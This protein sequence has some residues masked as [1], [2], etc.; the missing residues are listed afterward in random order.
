VTSAEFLNVIEE[1]LE[2]DEGILDG[3]ELI[4]DLEGWDSL[5]VVSFI[6]EVDSKLDLALNPNLISNANS[7]ADLKALVADK[8]TG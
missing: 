6:A 5:A 1:I 2:L 7:I 3:S 4:N 8:L